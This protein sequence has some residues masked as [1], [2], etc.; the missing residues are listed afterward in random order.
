MPNSVF[1]G[2]AGFTYDKTVFEVKAGF[3]Q[4]RFP[5]QSHGRIRSCKKIVLEVSAG[6]MYA[7]ICIQ[8]QRLILLG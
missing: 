8:N 7:K 6:F 4:S 2:K 1:K 5:I 3:Y